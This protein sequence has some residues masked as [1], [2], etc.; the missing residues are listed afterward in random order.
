MLGASQK[1]FNFDAF[2]TPL[3][4]GKLKTMTIILVKL[5]NL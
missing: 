5:L 1:Q 4:S 3:D 2:A